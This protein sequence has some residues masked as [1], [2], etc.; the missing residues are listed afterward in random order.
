MSARLTL[1]ALA[2]LLAP[3]LPA[4]A[5]DCAS[6]TFNIWR[7]TTCWLYGEQFT[8]RR[9]AVRNYETVRDAIRLTVA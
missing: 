3:S 9:D 5:A 4:M 6:H 2:L 8:R 1:S 7:S